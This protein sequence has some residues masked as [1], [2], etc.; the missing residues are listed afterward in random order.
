MADLQSHNL[1]LAS[2]WNSCGL[3][4]LLAR[5]R[6]QD[7]I[8]VRLVL[9]RGATNSSQG[10][11]EF[12]ACCSWPFIFVRHRPPHGEL[13]AVFPF[14]SVRDCSPTFASVVGQN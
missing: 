13:L 6:L 10:R 7:C 9:P 3:T 8:S 14:A 11:V 1:A 4:K 2:F 5:Q 12:L